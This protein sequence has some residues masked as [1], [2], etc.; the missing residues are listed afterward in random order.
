MIGSR[1]TAACNSPVQLTRSRSIINCRVF[2]HHTS[3]VCYLDSSWQCQNSATTRYKELR[4]PP[5][6]ASAS[7]S[8]ELKS[9]DSQHSIKLCGSVLGWFIF[10]II[11]NLESKRLLSLGFDVSFAT[12]LQLFLTSIVLMVTSPTKI[13]L[14]LRD[15]RYVF[16]VCVG[17]YGGNFYGNAAMSLMSVSLVNIVKSLEPFVA[18]LASWALLGKRESKAKVASIVPVVVGVALC[19]LSDVSFTSGGFAACM[20][21]NVFHVVKSLYSRIYFADRLQFSGYQIFYTATLGSSLFGI[22][23]ILAKWELVNCLSHTDVIISLITSSVGY[24]INSLC[25]FNVMSMVSPLSYSVLNIHKRTVIIVST[26]V[27]SKQL[28]SALTA[29]GVCFANVGL[30]FYSAV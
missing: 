25:A 30:F 13:H 20:L 9:T 23:I 17:Q 12:I 26:L 2:R 6:L 7:S 4:V 14:S 24:F 5:L 19:N 21:S 15:L 1:S 10:S 18:L 29:L 27:L 22:P 11:Y 8:S 3:S 16:L 28:P